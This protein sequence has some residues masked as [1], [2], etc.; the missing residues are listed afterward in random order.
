M[1]ELLLLLYAFASMTL[2]VCST[3]FHVFCCV[4]EEVFRMTARIDYTGIVLMIVVSFYPFM[5]NWFYCTPL[6]SLVY[7]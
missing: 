4:N 5:Y 3:L 2:C 7:R 6:W 1:H